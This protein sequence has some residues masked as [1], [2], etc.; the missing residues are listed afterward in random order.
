M[1]WIGNGWH[2]KND[3]SISKCVEANGLFING[4]KT[5]VGSYP[6]RSD[7]DEFA[8]NAFTRPNSNRVAIATRCVR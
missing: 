4:I 6:Q 2:L 5:I 7:A 3:C 1:S 8:G